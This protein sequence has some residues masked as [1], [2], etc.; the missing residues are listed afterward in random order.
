MLHC[1]HIAAK[2][3]EITEKYR[4]C[5]K[6]D[7]PK[8]ASDG[9][10]EFAGIR[11]EAIRQDQF[12]HPNILRVIEYWFQFVGLQK[13]YLVIATPLCDQ[14]FHDW[15][16]AK[17]DFTKARNFLIQVTHGLGHRLNLIVLTT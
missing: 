5:F 16:N 10:T 3:I 11:E 7:K 17:Y 13:I 1:Q 6:F 14:N 4:H 15:I 2:A 9:M 8:F 12:K